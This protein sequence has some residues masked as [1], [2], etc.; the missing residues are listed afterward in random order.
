MQKTCVDCK[1]KLT[2]HATPLRCIACAA[3]H[4][5][6]AKYG[7][8]AERLEMTC[9]VCRKRFSDYASNRRKGKHFFCSHECRAAYTGVTN[10]IRLGGDGRKKPKW[11]K[12]HLY[13]LRHAERIRN[14]ATRYYHENRTV[15]LSRKQAADRALKLEVISAYGGQCACCGE[16]HI[17]FLTIDHTNCDGAEHRARCGKGRKVYADLRARG[18]PKSGYRCLCLNC[19][20]SIGFYGYCP[21]KPHA[22]IVVDK[23]PKNPGRKRT[24]R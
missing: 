19:N 7:R 18:F 4:R 8:P 20:I 9:E 21:H 23:R 3:R 13:Y 2:G 5:H 17:E 15:I 16:S 24:V 22:K 10:S 12:D 14:R 1:K 11:K 6:F